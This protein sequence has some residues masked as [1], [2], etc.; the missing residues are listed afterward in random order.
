MH[1]G[2]KSEHKEAVDEWVARFAKTG[3]PDGGWLHLNRKPEVAP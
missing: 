1:V 2:F 3:T